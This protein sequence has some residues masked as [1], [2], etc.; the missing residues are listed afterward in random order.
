MADNTSFNNVGDSILILI[1]EDYYYSEVS[2][3]VLKGDLGPVGQSGNDAR[4]RVIIFHKT[5]WRQA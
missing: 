4:M 1:G 5:K 3:V 2:N